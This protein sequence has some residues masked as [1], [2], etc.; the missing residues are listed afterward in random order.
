MKGFQLFWFNTFLVM[1][2]I[3]KMILLLFLL[4]SLLKRKEQKH[5]WAVSWRGFSYV[6]TSV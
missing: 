5:K 6:I 2:E 3:C 4:V 1:D